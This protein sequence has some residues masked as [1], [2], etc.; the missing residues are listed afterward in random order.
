MSYKILVVDDSKDMRDLM[1]LI[2][3]PE[4]YE[5]EEARDGNEALTKLDNETPPDLIFLDHVMEVMDG[6]EFL[7]QLGR[8]H[9]EVLSQVPIIMLTGKE[10]DEVEEDRVTEVVAKQVGVEPLLALVKRYLQ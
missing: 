2:F 10:A 6:P 8:T 4:G 7:T 5:V 1:A 3:K 9:P